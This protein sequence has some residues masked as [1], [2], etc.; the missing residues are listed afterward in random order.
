MD[1]P[2]TP[3]IGSAVTAPAI[4]PDDIKRLEDAF[5]LVTSRGG[6]LDALASAAGV[7]VAVAQSAIENPVTAG[8]LLFANDKAQDDGR[9]LKPVA[10]R[11]ALAM[12]QKLDEAI[13]AGALDVDDINNL[14]PKV[15]RVVEHADRIAA[16]R[17]NGDE[18]LTTFQF[19]HLDG[20]GFQF[21]AV[22]RVAN[23]ARIVTPVDEV[24]DV[25]SAE[26]RA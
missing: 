12:L 25:T 6:D 24:I 13:T 11:I 2:I 26:V 23:K 5:P 1:R 22:P 3:G 17:G 15:H 10:A 14:L 21:Q 18:G 4:S 9:L 20:G 16:A 19:T 7:P 8:R